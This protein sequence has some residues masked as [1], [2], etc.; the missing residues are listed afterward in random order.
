MAKTTV[1]TLVDDVD[2]SEAA[3][4]VRLAVNGDLFELDLSEAN[5]Q[6]LFAALEPFMSAARRLTPRSRRGAGR[7]GTKTSGRPARPSRASAAETAGPATEADLS[8]V[9]EWAKA[10]GFRVSAR[11]RLRAEV[12]DAYNK[13]N[14]GS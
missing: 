5:Q 6:K 8:S 11:G 2:G 9:R 12:L 4:T 1:T 14:Q 13:A 10:N 3:G 7:S